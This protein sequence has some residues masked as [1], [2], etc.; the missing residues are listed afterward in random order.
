MPDQRR[1]ELAHL[2][3]TGTARA[4]PPRGHTGFFHEALL[5]R[6]D[7]ELLAIAVPFLREGVTAGQPTLLGVNDRQQRLILDALRGSAGVTL[8]DQ[9]PYGDALRAVRHNYDVLSRLARAGWEQIRVL[10]EVPREPWRDWARYETSINH[11]YSDFPVWAMCPY[12]VS[13][14]DPAVRADVESTHTHLAHADGSER[15]NPRYTD[16]AALLADWARAGIDVVE[17]SPPALDLIDPTAARA[18]AEIERLTEP[19]PLGFDGANALSLAVGEVTKNAVIHGRPPVGVR[20]WVASNRLVVAVCDRGRGPRDPY[21]G[22]L[23]GDGST[24][25]VI[26]QAIDHVSLGREPGRFTVRLTACFA[27]APASP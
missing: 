26:F 14:I 15:P 10:G 5:Y 1:H 22:L 16:P 19:T 3:A 24:L 25:S 20:A 23:P 8:L 13:D 12:D 27:E 21:V 17:A 4:G 6:S 9:G 11:F 2:M 7:E 18:R